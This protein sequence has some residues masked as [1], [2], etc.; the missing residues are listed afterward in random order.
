ML[1]ICHHNSLFGIVIH[2]KDVHFVPKPIRIKAN[3]LLEINN[4]QTELFSI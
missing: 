1:H 4:D 3:V 2:Y